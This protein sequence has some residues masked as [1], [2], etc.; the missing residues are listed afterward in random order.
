M[1]HSERTTPDLH[2]IEPGE[3][4]FLVGLR[5]AASEHAPSPLIVPREELGAAVALARD[6][7][8]LTHFAAGLGPALEEQDRLLLEGEAH[9]WQGRIM[10]LNAVLVDQS[11]LVAS[12]LEKS[13]HPYVFFKGIHQ[14]QQ[15]Y[16]D[17]FLRPSADVDLLVP[18]QSFRAVVDLL[19]KVGF[20]PKYERS[21]WWETFL[22]ER[23]LYPD[24]DGYRAIDLHKGLQQPGTPGPA[25]LGA[26]FDPD[27]VITHRGQDW[28]VVPR[29]LL[30]LVP[31]MNLIKGLVS[32]SKMITHAW[33]LS[34]LLGHGKT[35]RLAA[36]MEVAE[37][38]R[39]TGTALIALRVLHMLFP[40]NYAEMEARLAKVMPGVSDT[41]LLLTLLESPA[42][43]NLPRRRDILVDACERR[44]GR[45]LS[46]TLWYGA[47]ELTRHFDQEHKAAVGT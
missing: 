32:K 25:D 37:E 9:R 27:A 44:V 47:S 39:L 23:H 33:D 16:R 45:V 6:N 41:D 14:Q 20:R 30:P 29:R 35:A 2:Q 13:G 46:Q 34:S 38:Q 5:L 18:R 22:G 1:R 42:R 19:G 4:L 10:K 36:F 43:S 24:A 26:F 17:Y 31:A 8:M 3:R 28:H 40:D 7:W 21:L 12:A 11:T 15:I